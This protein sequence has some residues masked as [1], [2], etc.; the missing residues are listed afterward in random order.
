MCSEIIFFFLIVIFV[1]PGIARCKLIKGQ[2]DEAEQ[3]L[4]FLT[5]TQQ[6]IGKSGVIFSFFLDIH[7]CKAA[8]SY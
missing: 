7:I 3:Q 8:M 2:L 5:V 4:E 6:S 1:Y